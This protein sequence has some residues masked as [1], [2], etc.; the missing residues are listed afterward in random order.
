M[1]DKMK[2]RLLELISKTNYTETLFH[3]V[4]GYTSGLAIPSSE[5]IGDAQEFQLWIQELKL[6]L[7]AIIPKR[8]M[9]LLKKL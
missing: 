2:D 4:G 6:E 3:I 5:M 8:K 1:I 7:Q 9:A